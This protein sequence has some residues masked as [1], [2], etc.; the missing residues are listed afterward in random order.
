[1]ILKYNISGLVVL[2]FQIILINY[3]MTI[4]LKHC[5]GRLFL[6][7]RLA[8]GVACVD[9]NGSFQNQAKTTSI[10]S[11]VTYFILHVYRHLDF[12]KDVRLLR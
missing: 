10:R 6:V 4:I 8:E 7:I 3:T 12:N 9:G 5:I 1:M 11:H 2:P